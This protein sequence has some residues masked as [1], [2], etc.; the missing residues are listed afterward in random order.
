M[1]F[2]LTE[3]IIDNIVQLVK[4]G[5][6]PVVAAQAVGVSDQTYYNWMKR[7]EVVLNSI[8]G[9]ILTDNLDEATAKLDPQSILLLRM[10][11][12]VK[13]AEAIGEC[14]DVRIINKGE[15]DAIPR[16]AKLSR[17]HRDRWAER[18][19]DSDG[20]RA[21]A[22]FLARLVEALNKPQIESPKLTEIPQS[23]VSRV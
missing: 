20:I 21:G 7:G 9:D 12:E 3:K 4:E 2:S 14:A 22:E 17:R 23:T 6:Y 1:R 13:K 8:T 18:V 10:L 11:V 19:P 16:L 15:K 5:N